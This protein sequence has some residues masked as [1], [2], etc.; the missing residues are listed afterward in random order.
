MAKSYRYQKNPK[1]PNISINGVSINEESVLEGPQW[2]VFAQKPSNHGVPPLVEIAGK[3]AS[4]EKKAEKPAKPADKPPEPADEEAP[5]LDDI[6][7]VGAKR[8]EALKKEGYTSVAD[9]ADADAED[10][11]EEINVSEAVAKDLIEYAKGLIG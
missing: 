10:L 2:D 8:A 1:H 6:N 9:V 5:E 3:G 11:A 7:G 4:V